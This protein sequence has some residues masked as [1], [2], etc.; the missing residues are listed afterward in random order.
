MPILVGP[1]ARL[2]RNTLESFTMLEW[3]M[4]IV[5]SAACGICGIWIGK[6]VGIPTEPGFTGSLLASSSPVLGI[7]VAVVAMVIGTFIGSLFTASIQSDAGF[8]CSCLGLAGL[9][10]RGGP[11]RPILQV[12]GGTSVFVK[13]SLETALLGALL[14]ATWYLF[15]K[16]FTGSMLL[17]PN[18]PAAPN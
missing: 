16:F 6:L 5:G 2:S 15:S 8:F 9:A 17:L 7:F 13:L 11:I 4:L 12:A 18:A 10:I 1:A 3:I 14:V